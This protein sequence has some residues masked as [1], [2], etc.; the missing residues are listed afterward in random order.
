MKDLP[1]PEDHGER[2]AV[3]RAASS[4]ELGSSDWADLLIE[5]YFCP[6]AADTGDE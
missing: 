3:A 1:Y 6:D 2:I 5:A 4:W